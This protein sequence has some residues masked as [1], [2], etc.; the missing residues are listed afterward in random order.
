MNLG[1]QMGGISNHMSGFMPPR[2]GEGGPF[3]C[4]KCGKH[5]FH[6]EEHGLENKSFF[7]F[8]SILFNSDIVKCPKCGSMRTYRDR[9]W[10]Y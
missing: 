4:R 7:G 8:I 1:K 2:P 3:I 5:F 10:R 6:H 9:R